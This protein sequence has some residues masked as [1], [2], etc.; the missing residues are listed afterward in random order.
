MTLA[1]AERLVLVL[2]EH[3]DSPVASTGAQVGTVLVFV[4]GL[5]VVIDVDGAAREHRI[6]HPATPAEAS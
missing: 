5:L 6:Y 4:R 3:G 1:Q 2:R